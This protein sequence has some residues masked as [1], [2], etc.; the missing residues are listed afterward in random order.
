MKKRKK[1]IYINFN[2]DK[3]K[4]ENATTRTMFFSKCCKQIGGSTVNTV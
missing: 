2:Y 4:Y 1:I 3:P